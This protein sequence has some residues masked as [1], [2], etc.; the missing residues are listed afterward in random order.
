MNISSIFNLGEVTQL[1]SLKYE[2]EFVFPAYPNLK[3]QKGHVTGFT[4]VLT[5]DSQIWVSPS[6]T[7]NWQIASGRT[8]VLKVIENLCLKDLKP[9]QKFR[10]VNKHDSVIGDAIAKRVDWFSEQSSFCKRLI[11]ETDFLPILCEGKLIF[12]YEGN[13][14]ILM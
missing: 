11:T 14:V 12:S 9:G 3:M 10:F 7:Y 13:R 4:E 6:K 5:N 2:D 8:R 1:S